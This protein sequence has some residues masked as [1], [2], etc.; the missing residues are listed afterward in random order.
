MRILQ[1]A[2]FLLLSLFAKS[3]TK[4]SINK[5]VRTAKFG[6]VYSFGSAVENSV[7]GKITLYPKTDSTMLFYLNVNRGARPFNMGTC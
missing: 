1:S 6:A 3:Q 4:T 2:S 5:T 7:S